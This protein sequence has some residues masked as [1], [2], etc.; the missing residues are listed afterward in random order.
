MNHQGKQIKT[1]EELGEV[2]RRRQSVLVPCGRGYLRQPAAWVI[3]TNGSVILYQLQRGMFLYIP[4]KPQ[5]PNKPPRDGRKPK[6]LK[7][8]PIL[9]LPYYPNL[10]PSH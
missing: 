2:A 5:D 1:L 7:P 10:Q 4:K 3:N 8:T 9:N 6:P